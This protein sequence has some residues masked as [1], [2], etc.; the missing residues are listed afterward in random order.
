[1]GLNLNQVLLTAL[2]NRVALFCPSVVS[3]LMSTVVPMTLVACDQSPA[4]DFL[5][6]HLG[7][8][9]ALQPCLL[10]HGLRPSFMKLFVLF[11]LSCV[12]NCTTHRHQFLSG[13][14]EIAIELTTICK[15]LCHGPHAPRCHG[16]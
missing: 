11:S 12:S 13:S 5:P 9:R 7:R 16:E 15:C 1:M 3:L 8:V 14:F 4:S 2:G 6:P 10:L